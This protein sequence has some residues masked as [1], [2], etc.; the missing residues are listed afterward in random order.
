AVGS[1]AKLAA[2]ALEDEEGLGPE[3]RPAVLRQRRVKRGA[4]GQHRQLR[5][6]IDGHIPTFSACSFI[7][8]PCTSD[9]PPRM[10]QATCTASV[11]CSRS[12]PFCRLSVV[13]AS[14]QYGHC[15]VCATASAISAFSRAVSAP[16][17][18]TAL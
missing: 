6:G 16:G 7:C 1:G 8:I 13:Y 14:M 11:I 15:T 17:A 9:A 4:A 10:A 18:K 2:C 5:R 12:A 3:R